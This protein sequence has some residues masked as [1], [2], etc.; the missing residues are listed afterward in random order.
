MR[1]CDDV[2]ARRVRDVDDPEFPRAH[3][4]CGLTHAMCRVMPQERSGTGYLVIDFGMTMPT[5]CRCWPRPLSKRAAT[6]AGVQPPSLPIHAIC[7]GCWKIVYE[8]SVRPRICP[9]TC[10]ACSDARYATS[11][12]FNAGFSSGGGSLPDFS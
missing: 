2:A 3:R 6:S 10:A 12:A 1:P 8:Y 4:S 11:G 7:L 9:F 5:C